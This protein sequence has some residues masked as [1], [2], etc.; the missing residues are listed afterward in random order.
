MLR[1]R[2]IQFTSQDQK[3]YGMLHLPEG[4]G[5][6]PA[7]TLLHG[8][9][10]TRVESHR[11]FVKAARAIAAEGL[12]ALRFDFRGSGESEGEFVDMTLQGEVADARRAFDFLVQQSEIDTGRLGLLGLSLG[13]VV[14]ICLAGEDPRLKA[15][16]L[17]STPVLGR[18]PGIG[19]GAVQGVDLSTLGEKGWV[20]WAGNR[21]GQAFFL[22]LRD[23][24]TLE[25]VRQFKGPVLVIHGTDD[26]LVPV[27]AGRRYV[28][29][30]AGRVEAH[31]VKGADHTFSSLHWEGDVIEKTTGWFLRHLLSKGLSIS[32]RL[33]GD[34][35]S[36]PPSTPK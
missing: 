2:Q 25:R 1:E 12:A 4:E 7:I 18:S 19:F 6:F 33:A 22:S 15:L 16:A 10:G 21:V 36:F 3:V 17:W 35:P 31:W 11:L 14:G 29:T 32:P 28:E 9:T 24:D 34:R 5:P 27:D 8:F 30:L 26:A 20:D 13:G 23:L